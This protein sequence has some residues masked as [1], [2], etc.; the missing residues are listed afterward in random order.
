M[1]QWE[2]D[3]RLANPNPSDNSDFDDD[4]GVEYVN[5]RVIQDQPGV[6]ND[7]IYRN[8]QIQLSIVGR[9]NVGKSTLVNALIEQDRVI[10][11]STPGT[12]RDPI[13]V[14]W[15]YKG[16]K[17]HLVDTAGVESNKKY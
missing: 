12:T 6:S 4:S 16:Q 8:K 10:V 11:D 5:R 3:F 9:V 2:Q 7:N 15:V 1:R 17:V 14:E 13:S